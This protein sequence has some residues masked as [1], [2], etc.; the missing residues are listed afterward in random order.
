MTCNGCGNDHARRV[1]VHYL[2]NG[3]T[4]ECCDVC[5]RMSSTPIPDVYC[6]ASGYFDPNLANAAN[7]E[8]MFINSKRHKA[9]VMKSLNL[10]EVGDRKNRVTG[11]VTPY[12]ADAK[13]RARY[14]RDNFGD[15]K[16]H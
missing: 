16:K 12:I 1:V 4:A 2:K 3:D 5:G 8:G 14:C 10:V 9:E 6:P 15:N 7:P 13:A 11:K